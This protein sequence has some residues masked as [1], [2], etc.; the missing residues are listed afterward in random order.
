M[1]TNDRFPTV[2]KS[3]INKKDTGLSVQAELAI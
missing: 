2:P 3:L 1:M